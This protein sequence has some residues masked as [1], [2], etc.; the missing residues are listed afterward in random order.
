MST[1][2]NCRTCLS[3][4][5]LSLALPGCDDAGAPVQAKENPA[6]AQQAAANPAPAAHAPEKKRESIIGKTTAVVVDAKKAMAENPA[7]VPRGRKPLGFDPVTQ[8][9][10]AYVYIR[11]KV[12]TLGM[13]Q[14]I[15]VHKALND[16]W[17]NYEEFMKIMNDN[18]ITFTALKPWEKYGYD[19]DTG[20]IMILEDKAEQKR[21]FEAA[22]L[23][24]KK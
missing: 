8:S 24:F 15:R 10:N 13:E 2:P 16:R 3:L 21:I 20:T 5:T 12:S 6:A 4:I 11:S 17:P 1:S 19:S 18:H 7:L 9:T 14:S 22:G 23:E